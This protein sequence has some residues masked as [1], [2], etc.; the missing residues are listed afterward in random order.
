MEINQPFIEK[1]E[2]TPSGIGIPAEVLYNP[3]LSQTE[4]LLFGQLRNLS[5]S[6]KGC[7]ASNQYL[8]KILGVGPQSISNS[9]QNLKKYFYIDVEF[10]KRKITNEQDRK[11]TINPNLYNLYNSLVKIYYDNFDILNAESLLKKLDEHINKIISGYKQSYINKGINKGIN[12][13]KDTLKESAI[14][15]VVT[16]EKSNNL[17]QRIEQENVAYNKPTNLIQEQVEILLQQNSD[18]QEIINYWNNLPKPLSDHKNK[19]T[20]TYLQICQNL[21]ALL[22]KNYKDKILDS[23]QTYFDLIKDPYFKLS[24]KA[25]GVIV[26]LDHFIKVNGYLK[27]QIKG[28][29]LLIPWFEKCSAQTLSQLKEKYSKQSKDLYPD[30]TN[31]LKENWKIIIN[32][33]KIFTVIEENI[34]KKTAISVYNYFKNI[35]D[36]R[37]DSYHRREYPGTCAKFIIEALLKEHPDIEMVPGWLYSDNFFKG[38][39]EI[40]LRK[41]GYLLD[42]YDNINFNNF[43]RQP[44]SNPE[45]IE[46]AKQQEEEKEKEIREN[47]LTNDDFL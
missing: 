1:H 24:H 8:G 45:D 18:I 2:Q 35:K 7:Y 39:L 42:G 47:C 38:T 36:F 30:I 23:I 19:N 44:L 20:K 5:R 17:Q 21:K 29:D 9:I 32:E 27:D 11:I 31:N 25:P 33:K 14:P 6:S 13:S 22:K 34:L 37:F 43:S 12:V 16:D 3:N 15:D 41:I 4:K 40:Y 28:L 46:Y 26:S 10:I